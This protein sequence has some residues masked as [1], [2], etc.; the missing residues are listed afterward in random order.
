M[1]FNPQWAFFAAPEKTYFGSTSMS[2]STYLIKISISPIF[3]LKS[4]YIRNVLPGKK[5][6]IVREQ[7]W[8]IY[9]SDIIVLSLTAVS[10]SKV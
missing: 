7:L 2:M 10:D 3:A 9:I 1:H 6:H 5:L 4:Q 8:G